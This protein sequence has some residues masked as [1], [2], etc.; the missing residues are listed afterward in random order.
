MKKIILS[1]NQ[2][3]TVIDT[4]LNEQQ[5]SEFKGGTDAQRIT[6]ALLSKNF[7]LPDGLKYENYYYGANIADVINMSRGERS[8]FL[9][10]FKPANAYSQDSKFYMD[11]IYVNKEPLQ[12]SGSKTFK[13]VS[14]EV[15]ATHNGLLALA[16]AMDYMNG[17]GGFLTITFGGSTSGKE[18]EAERVG[19]GIKFDSNRSLN[20]KPG[21]NLLFEL[22]CG[23][24]VSPEYRD[25]GSF[26]NVKKETTNEQLIS[27]VQKT[28]GFICQGFYGFM[29]MSKK[30]E[31][32]QNLTPKGFITTIDFNIQPFIQKLIQLQQ[33]PDKEYDENTGKDNVYN[34]KK[35]N[36]LYGIGSSFE[37]NLINVLKSTY[38]KNFQIYVENYLPNS[39]SQ[40]LP[41]IKNVKFDYNGLGD[42]HDRIFH[43][44]VGGSSSS[45]SSIKQ[46]NTN[47][48]TGN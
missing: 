35:K 15:F 18:A 7:G 25:M 13:F 43:S 12:N 22:L 42:S 34:A 28:L 24:S 19:G 6:H 29:D 48:Q 26:I 32:L 11:S 5:V 8:K 41:L 14:G 16:R 38:M 44:Y 27:M 40:I 47:Y 20:Q 4:I 10:V 23:L 31:I 39:S 45:N 17:N 46:K 37:E 2:V 1:E 3:K 36:Q 30:D 21:L 33:I 9:S